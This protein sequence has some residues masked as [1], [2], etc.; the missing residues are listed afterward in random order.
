LCA[1]PPPTRAWRVRKEDEGAKA[2]IKDT[3]N[4]TVLELL[5]QIPSLR[6][7][8]GKISLRSPGDD[9]DAA[10]VRPSDGAGDFTRST[11]SKASDAGEAPAQARGVNGV[12]TMEEVRKHAHMKDAWIVVDGEVYDITPF[13]ATHW[14]WSSAGKNSTIIAIMSALGGDCSRDFLDV[15]KGLADWKK[16]LVQLKGFKI[17]R[18]AE[19]EVDEQHPQGEVTYKTWDELIEMGRMPALAVE[20]Q[21]QRNQKWNEYLR[22]R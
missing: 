19:G 2:Y 22:N 1:S 12:Y 6:V 17:G 7:E 5:Q 10:H 13:V 11:K 15:H 20:E 16:I 21:V 8:D 4:T 14:G 9:A 18:L 3:L